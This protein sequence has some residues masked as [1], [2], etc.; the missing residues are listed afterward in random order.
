M[1]KVFLVMLFSF[2]C[3]FVACTDYKAKIE[4]DTSWSGAF[5]N[6]TVDGTGSRS[7]DLP[8][9]GIQCCTVQKQNKKGRLKITIIND[10]SNPLLSTE[11]NS[12]ETTAEYGVVSACTK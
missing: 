8:D 10:T 7:I 11:L 9:D 4:S 2:S 1:K 12:A 6:S 3:L 5:G